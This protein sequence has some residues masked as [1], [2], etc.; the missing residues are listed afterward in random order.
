M[1]IPPWCTKGKCPVCGYPAIVHTKGFYK[2]SYDCWSHRSINK[3]NFFGTV[4]D[5]KKLKK[6]QNDVK[7]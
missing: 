1:K 5:A 6:E 2:G 3:C 4:E 7:N